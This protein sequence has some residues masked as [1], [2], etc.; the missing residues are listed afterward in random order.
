LQH[1]P[2]LPA[3]QPHQVGLAAALPPPQVGVRVLDAGLA[4]SAA[5]ELGDAALPASM[6]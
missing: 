2:R 1:C 6:S 4:A 3:R 5:Q